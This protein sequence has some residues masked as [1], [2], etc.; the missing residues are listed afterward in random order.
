MPDN[1]ITEIGFSINHEHSAGRLVKSLKNTTVTVWVGDAVDTNLIYLPDEEGGYK[2]IVLQGKT[3]ENAKIIGHE[4]DIRDG[5]LFYIYE[6]EQRVD[7]LD[8]TILG[9]VLNAETESFSHTV[10]T[11]RSEDSITYTRT[12]A[13]QMVDYDNYI[14]IDGSPTGTG[15]IDKAVSEIN[16]AFKTAPEDFSSVDEDIND[17]IANAARPCDDDEEGRYTKVR[18]EKI[19]KVKCSVEISETVTKRINENDCCVESQTIS[20]NWSETGMVTISINGNIKGDCENFKG[21]DELREVTKTKY[22]YALECF[23]EEEIRQKIIDEYEKH[24]LEECETDLCLALRINNSSV[25]HCYQDGTIN[26]SFTAQEEEV[27][28]EDNSAKVYIYDNET[29]DGC[30]SNIN[31]EFDISAPINNSFIEKNPDYLVGDCSHTEPTNTAEEAIELCR[32][33]LRQISLDK[34]LDPSEGFFGPLNLTI[35][36][37]PSKGTISGTVSFSNDPKFDVVPSETVIKKKVRETTTCQTEIR[38]NRYSSP[39]ACPIIQKQVMRPGSIQECLEVVAYPCAT[40]SDL[41]KSLDIKIPDGAVVTDSNSN[42]S[43]NAGS[44][45]ANSCVTYHTQEQLN[46]CS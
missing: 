24:K 27:L 32:E 26:Y 12:F 41:K 33:A 29:K 39:C 30:I 22:E 2:D 18:S 3:Y 45:T 11:S 9:T 10:S 37:C 28:E 1:V 40:L 38:D 23:D 6:I 46:Q 13:L 25:T 19:D 42:F 21:C 15:L 5:Q 35:N 44:L 17:V 7:P 20:L 4:T 14:A 36:E 43:V 8:C 16:E 31:R 34:K